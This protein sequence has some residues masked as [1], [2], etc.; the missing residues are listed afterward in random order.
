M[1]YR[2]PPGRTDYRRASWHGGIW[3]RPDILCAGTAKNTCRVDYG[4]EESVERSRTGIKRI[5]AFLVTQI[6]IAF[7]SVGD[8]AQSDFQRSIS[9]SAIAA[10]ASTLVMALLVQGPANLQLS[11]VVAV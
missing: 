2:G 7:L 11:E 3:V 9:M 4:R 1:E 6:I 5:E 10:I 8:E